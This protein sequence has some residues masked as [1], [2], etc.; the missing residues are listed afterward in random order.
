MGIFDFATKKHGAVSPATPQAPVDNSVMAQLALNSIH[1]GVVIV[2]RE[3]VIRFINPAAVTMIGCGSAANALNLDFA[4]LMKFEAN[5]GTRIDDNDNEIVKSIKNN[6]SFESREFVLISKQDER[7]TPIA[8]TVTPSGDAK[9][10]RII[11]FRN[12]SKELEEEGAQTE[13][14]STA[15]H[16]M[17]TPVASIE[18]YLGLALN[19]QTATIDDRARQYLES[20]HSSSQHLGRLF[21]DLLDVTKLDDKRIR[22]HPVPLELSGFVKKYTDEYLPKFQEKKLTYSF[23]ANDT[24]KNGKKGAFSARVLEQVVYTFADPDFLGEILANLI[25]NAI[26]YTPEGG[27]VWVN[28]QGDGDRALINVTDTGIGISSDDLQH[29]FQKF[30]RADNSHTRTVGGTG[31]GLYLVKQ[32]TEAMNGKVWAESAFGEGSTFYVS[33]PRLTGEEYE[34]RQIAVQNEKAVAMFQ[35]QVKTADDIAAQNTGLP[36]L[37][38]DVPKFDPSVIQ[39][40]VAPQPAP[41]TPPATPVPQETQPVSGTPAV[42]TPQMVQPVL[43]ASVAPTAPEAQPQPQ[44]Q[45]QPQ[46]QTSVQSQ[47]VQL[48]M[49][50]QIEPQPVTTQV[51]EPVE[52]NAQTQGPQIQYGHLQYEQPVL[53]QPSIPTQPPVI[54]QPAPVVSPVQPVPNPTPPPS[55]VVPGVPTPT[56]NPP[57]TQQTPVQNNQNILQ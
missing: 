32:R 9:S 34:K 28:V 33:L 39:Q 20:A 52:Q 12:I 47:P 17:R 2:N 37:S 11:T 13:F 44:I 56:A 18:G 5:D 53:V 46:V 15:S 31:L 36:E 49:Q 30:Y 57:L 8:I 24:R 22:P 51:A 25:E 54:A 19:P 4:L 21:Q 26:K 43:E 14:V 3:G 41:E 7:K 10:D 50:Q 29:I 35:A 23:G 40:P 1:D 6:A 48:V 27:A 45:P 16:E 38:A 42:P 55:I